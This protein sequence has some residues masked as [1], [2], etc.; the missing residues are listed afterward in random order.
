MF[1]EGRPTVSGNPRG[2]RFAP[3]S[4]EVSLTRPTLLQR[5]SQERGSCSCDPPDPQNFHSRLCDRLDARREIGSPLAERR[6]KGGGPREP[7][8]P[9]LHC[10]PDEGVD[11]LSKSRAVS[12][13]S[14][15]RSESTRGASLCRGCSP[16]RC[17]WLGSQLVIGAPASST[18]QARRT[19]IVDHQRPPEADLRLVA[20]A[21]VAP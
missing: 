13:R 8:P 4:F 18:M 17:R 21:V 19:V 3:D 14:M 7:L 1:N 12:S 5:F 2:Q 11:R 9:E 16:P 15:S 20:E 10:S 6:W